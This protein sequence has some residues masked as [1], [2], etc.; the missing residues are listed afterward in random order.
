MI[1]LLLALLAPAQAADGFAGLAY[2]PLSRGDLTWVL[3][4]RTTGTGVG[5]FD[6]ATRSSLVPFGGAWFN[7]VGVLGTLGITRISTS[8][9]AGD[10]VRQR[11]WGVVRPGV[12]VRWAMTARETD[13]PVPWLMLGAAASIPSARDTSNGFTETE[14]NEADQAATIDRTRLGGF[15]GRLG[16][17]VD[18]AVLPHLSIGGELAAELYTSALR[19]SDLVAVTTVLGTRGALLLT[20]TWGESGSEP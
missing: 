5:E 19:G 1:G 16:G 20:F 6:G 4:E 11:H 18:Y 9:R 10:I 13:K 14:Q 17:G 7:R 8:A 15:G 12:D 2:T 3:E